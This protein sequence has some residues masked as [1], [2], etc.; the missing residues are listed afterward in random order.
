MTIT[1]QQLQQCIHNAGVPIEKRKQT[2]DI[3]TQGLTGYR[4]H[5]NRWYYSSASGKK[6]KKPS[7][8]HHAPKGR[9]DQADARNILISALCRAWI[10]GLDSTP[11]LNHK[12]NRDT[13]FAK[14]AMEIMQLEGIGHAH[15]HLEAYWS[16]RKSTW[17]SNDSFRKMANFRGE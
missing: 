10:Y 17:E 4:E 15:Q 5:R 2:F 3:I 13:D 16:F 7:L 9:H 14:F 6:V 11:T 8:A 12:N 1:I